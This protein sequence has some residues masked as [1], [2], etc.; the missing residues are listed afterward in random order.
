MSRSK[1]SRDHTSGLSG[2]TGPARFSAFFRSR[3]QAVRVPVSVGLCLVFGVLILLAGALNL[4]PAVSAAEGHGTHGYYIA[5]NFVCVDGYRTH[6]CEWKGD[7]VSRPG[8]PALRSY[9]EFKG[10]LPSNIH[11]GEAVPAVDTGAPS[12][13]FQ[14]GNL[15]SWFFALA[16]TVFGGLFVLATAALIV[17][18]FKS[19]SWP[20]P[21]IRP[22][23]FTARPVPL[24]TL[25]TTG[26][27]GC[28][29]T[30]HVAD[31]PPAYFLCPSLAS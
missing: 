6:T 16:L 15:Y 20:F 8:G 19:G 23:L 4:G 21:V 24:L 7:F 3:W 28:P 11:E 27:A 10:H 29:R 5:R 12:E 22:R 31:A 18:R 1:T 2:P 26:P 13:V 25:A 17:I 30:E 14:P 9:V